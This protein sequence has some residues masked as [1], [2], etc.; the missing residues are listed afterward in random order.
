MKNKNETIFFW[1]YSIFFISLFLEDIAYKDTF[2]TISNIIIKA[3]KILALFLLIIITNNKIKRKEYYINKTEIIELTIAIILFICSRD[4]I[5]I[6]VVLLGIN[7]KN[8]YEEKLLKKS[9]ILIV[10]S[11]IIVVIL[12]KIGI[13]PNIETTRVYLGKQK[14]I[15][16]GFYHSNVLPLI[17]FY[18]ITYIF[19][20]HNIKIGKR[21]FIWNILLAISVIFYSY[22]DSRNAFILSAIMIAIIIISELIPKKK[23]KK[24]HKITTKV[25]SKSIY[26]IS[27]TSVVPSYL[28]SLNIMSNIWIELD[29]IFTNRCY[30]GAE[31]IKSI[32]LHFINFMS[33]NSF[34]KDRIV[35]DNGYLYFVLRYGILSILPL[36]FIFKSLFDCYKKEYMKCLILFFIIIINFTDNDF[37]SYGFLPYAIIGIENMKNIVKNYKKI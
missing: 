29:K 30:L 15:S 14:R 2:Q 22:C 33:S 31:K 12:C 17:I 24:I 11:T 20:F 13:I 26:I 6:I 10:I 7:Y 34:Q 35:I 8:E 1:S 32:G 36:Y 18:T 5:L 19:M 28:Y 25:F 9:I 37:L 3:L 27:F 16:F 21:I 23:R 4:F